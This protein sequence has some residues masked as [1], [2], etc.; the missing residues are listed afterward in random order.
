[1]IPENRVDQLV[2]RRLGLERNWDRRN[3]EQAQIVALRR[4]VHHALAGSSL[5]RQRLAGLDP[6]RLRTARDLDRIP[7][8]DSRDIVVAGH[9]LQCIS[10]SRV[11]RVVTLQTSGSTGQAK[12]LMFTSEDLEATMDFFLNGMRSLVDTTD[13]VMVMLPYQQPDCVGDLLIKALNAGG[14]SA[15]GVWPPQPPMK[16]FLLTNRLTCAVGLPQQL[17]TLAEEIGPGLLR[18]MLLCS[19]YA[20]PALRARIE[21]ACRCRTFLHYGTTE[22]G[23]GG[24]VECSR[25][26]GCHIR[27]SD[28]LMEIIDPETGKNLA[29]GELG[30]VVI[31]TLGREAMPLLRYRTGDLARLTHAACNCGGITARLLDIRG[32]LAGRPLAGGLLHS[33]DLDDHL[34]Q[35]PGLLE[36]RAT[37][38]REGEERLH[39]AYQAAPSAGRID[40]QIAAKLLEI[41]AILEASL[42]GGLVVG[43]IVQVKQFTVSHTVKQ[44]I[45]DL[46]TPGETDAPP[47]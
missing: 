14:I 35:I 42:G 33:Q 27:E 2:A 46:R 15:V 4:T 7:L 39:I 13:R 18:T 23:L 3:L 41:P 6:E 36:Y 40:E 30:E 45:L 34:F 29:D 47:F 37:L 38:D 32:R 11:A 17:L 10:Q 8:L 5:Y 25:H 26:D 9:R 22:S 20:S 21:H 24:A 44:T 1:M 12:R 16:D 31:T 19:D 43:E 28:L